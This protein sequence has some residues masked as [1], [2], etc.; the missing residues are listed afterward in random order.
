[1]DMDNIHLVIH[2][3]IQHSR[4]TM[5]TQTARITTIHKRISHV[6]NHLIYKTHMLLPPQPPQPPPHHQLPRRRRQ[7]QQQQPPPPPLLLLIL[8]PLPPLHLNQ[9]RHSLHPH[10]H[11]H[12]CHLLVLPPVL[13]VV[14]LPRPRPRPRLR[15]RLMGKPLKRHPLRS[16]AQ[17]SQ[18]SC[19]RQGRHR[20]RA[21]ASCGL[22]VCFGHAL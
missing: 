2:L 1:M 4:T 16:F 17:L 13:V 9:S 18:R 12:R 19:K 10:S 5:P 8:L 22:S 7:Q 15:L 14:L 20:P 11:L 3:T 6:M 21:L